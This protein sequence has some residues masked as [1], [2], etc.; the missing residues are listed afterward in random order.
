MGEGRSLVG[1]AGSVVGEGGSVVG[2]AGSIVGGGGSIL[3]GSILGGSIT[4]NESGVSADESGM[5]LVNLSGNPANHGA[6]CSGMSA[7]E[8]ALLTHPT[9]LRKLSAERACAPHVGAL[10]SH[11]CWESEHT[12]RRFFRPPTHFSH[13]S[14]PTF[15]ISHLLFLFLPRGACSMSSSTRST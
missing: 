8:W 5:G 13:M 15:P 4:V 12:S 2:E 6:D 11:A 10:L 7:D 9:L 3:G 1:E 14:H